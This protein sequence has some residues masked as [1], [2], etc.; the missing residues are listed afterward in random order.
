VKRGRSFVA[1][2]AT[3]FLLIEHG[4]LEE[5]AEPERSYWSFAG[6]R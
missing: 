3:R 4:R 1:G 5:V 2:I 6:S